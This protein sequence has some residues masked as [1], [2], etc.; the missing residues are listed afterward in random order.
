MVTYDGMDVARVCYPEVT[1]IC[2][3]VKYL[4]E[5]SARSVIKLIDGK[6]RV[7]HRQILSVE[8]RQGQS[9]YPVEFSEQSLK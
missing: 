4:A 6:E 3:N 7:P 5:N 9:T 1:S 2:Q 8:L